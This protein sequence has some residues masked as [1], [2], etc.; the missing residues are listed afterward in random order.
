MQQFYNA[1]VMSHQS[2]YYFCVTYE[3]S[4]I[5]CSSC[6]STGRNAFLQKKLNKAF[7]L[8]SQKS[9]AK[10]AFLPGK[11][12]PPAHT[13]RE[14]FLCAFPPLFT[15]YLSTAGTTKKHIVAKDVVGLLIGAVVR[16]KK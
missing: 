7:Q 5:D 2:Q 9:Q 11:K 1:K 16:T 14:Y 15:G 3:N 13:Q 8:I 6:M 10:N 4:D 12:N